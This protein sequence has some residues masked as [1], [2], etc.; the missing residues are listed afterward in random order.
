MKT[1]AIIPTRDDVV[2][3]DNEVELLLDAERTPIA[4]VVDLYDEVDG[5]IAAIQRKLAPALERR[6]TLHEVLFAR[7]TA[8][9]AA[10]LA[11]PAFATIAIEKVPGKVVPRVDVLV[12]LTQLKHP[13]GTPVIPEADL[14]KAIWLEQPEPFWKTHLTYLKKLASYG[15]RVKDILERGLPTADAPAK[16][17][18]VRAQT[19]VTPIA[20]DA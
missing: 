3:A 18:L 6:K 5:F 2:G 4:T 12:E 14:R 11:H 17:V 13:D 7:M 10:R 20:G 19:D 16:L 15:S 1:V 9:G 8:D